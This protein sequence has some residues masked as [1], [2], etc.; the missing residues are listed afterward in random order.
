MEARTEQ[1]P[2]L[3]SARGL[4]L[5]RDGIT[6]LEQVD[7]GIRRGE[8]VTI[9][10][11]NGAGKTS[12]LRLLLGLAQPS[13]GSI[14]RAPGLRIGY[15]PQQ[16][17]IDPIL[18]LSVARFLALGGAANRAAD[19]H[20]VGAAAAETGIDH[21]LHAP[22]QSLSGGEWQRV[23]LA[24]ALL[25]APDL[26]ILDEP[27]SNIDVGGQMDFYELLAGLRR[28]RGCSILMVSHDLHM[29]MRA[30]DVVICLDRRVCCSGAAERIARHP[31]YARLFAPEIA[32]T[33]AIYPH[34]HPAASSQH[35]ESSGNAPPRHKSQHKS[36]HP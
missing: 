24:R 14:T 11:P 15:L 17:H 26:L 4:G 2:P 9:I 34:H 10:G 36:Q 30:T 29:V 3:I 23:L 13:S 35:S 5:Q 19:K 33:L 7:V 31:E 22:L 18:P 32:R 16:P 21:R 25:I 1:H 27:T 20:S 8:I 28:R 6:I 12:L